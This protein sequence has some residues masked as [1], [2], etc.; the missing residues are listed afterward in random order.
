VKRGGVPRPL[1]QGHK[2]VGAVSAGVGEAVVDTL[3][4][5]CAVLVIVGLWKL[6]RINRAALSH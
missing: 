5:A 2:G 4:V 3:L 6:A 1:T